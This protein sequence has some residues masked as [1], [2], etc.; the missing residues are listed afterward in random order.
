[1]SATPFLTRLKPRC[2]DWFLPGNGHLSRQ[3][4][5]RPVSGLL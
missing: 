2:P 3:S 1:M 4:L 5:K